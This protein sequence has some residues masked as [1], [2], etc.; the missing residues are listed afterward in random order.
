MNDEM[1]LIFIIIGV[2]LFIFY[3]RSQRGHYSSDIPLEPGDWRVGEDIKPG[4]G[5]LVAASGTG[6][7]SIMERG[8][9][10]WTHN[11]KLGANNPAVPG[12]YRNL[13]LHASD[14]LQINGNLKV[15]ITPPTAI[16]NGEGAVL[17]L[18]TY[19]FGL[20][21][22]PAKYNLKAEEGDGQI[23]LPCDSH[24]ES[25]TDKLALRQV[26]GGLEPRDRTLIEMRYL[27]KMT[28][29]AVADHLGMTQVQ[30]S[31]RERAILL[32]MR[33]KLLN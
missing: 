6:D 9:G 14:I 1:T 21:I 29:Q 15:L 26:L 4:K 22:P 24:E 18:G 3:R 7:I 8:N 32:E 20:D 23:D 25:V 27:R 28:Q 17:T 16:A 33:Q 13:T 5:D 30:V 12:K 19:Q 11:F 10:V 2:V 31:R